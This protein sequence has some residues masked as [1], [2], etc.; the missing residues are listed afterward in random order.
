MNSGQTLVSPYVDG[1]LD[2]KG[3]K[4]LRL[5]GRDI[6][7]YIYKHNDYFRSIKNKKSH[8]YWMS[9]TIKESLSFFKCK[10][11]ISL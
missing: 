9:Q 5:G 3:V 2:P 7:H 8:H 1:Q 4:S 6:T 10:E 11:P